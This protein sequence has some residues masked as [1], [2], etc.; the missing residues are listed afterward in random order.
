MGKFRRSRK[1]QQ[2]RRSYRVHTLA[3]KLKVFRT[4]FLEGNVNTQSTIHWWRLSGEIPWFCNDVIHV[5]L[6]TGIR[7]KYKRFRESSMLHIVCL[8]FVYLGAVFRWDRLNRFE[9]LVNE[10]KSRVQIHLY[11]Q[12]A[13]SG[14]DYRGSQV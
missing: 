10:A 7:Y 3:P 9:S 6:E 2:E 5:Q 12:I 1:E 14:P 13:F 4:P 11:H 8:R